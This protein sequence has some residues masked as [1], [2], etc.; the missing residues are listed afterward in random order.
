MEN[1]HGL[2]PELPGLK[3]PRQVS[4]TTPKHLPDWLRRQLEEKNP[5]AFGR[6]AQWK[7]CPRCQLVTLAG[8]DAYDDY[9]GHYTTDPAQLDTGQ[10][11]AALLDGRHTFELRTDPDG[12]KTIS[13][14]DA[15]RIRASPAT[16][17]RW[18]V[19]PEHRCGAPL[20]RKLEPRKLSGKQN[21]QAPRKN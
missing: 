21:A 16:G 19:I 3:K 18:P 2:Q 1:G 15:H 7:I 13:R 4:G 20:G 10:E 9:A 11:L 6:N 8:W 12:N 14:R 5:N 17:H